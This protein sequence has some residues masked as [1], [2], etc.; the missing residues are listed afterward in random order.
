MPADRPPYVWQC[1]KE[2][3]TTLVFRVYSAGDGEWVIA[4]ACEEHEL[5]VGMKLTELGGERRD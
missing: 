3:P 5:S 4:L 2:R 1:C